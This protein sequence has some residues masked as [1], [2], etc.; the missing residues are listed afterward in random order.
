LIVLATCAACAACS[1]GSSR[2]PDGGPGD[3]GPGD[4]S[5]GDGGTL[6]CAM[7]VAAYC[8][9]AGCKTALADARQDRA[10]CPASITPCGEFDVIVKSQIDTSTSYFYFRGQL[11]AVDHTLLPGR[12]SCIAG[13][14]T[15]TPPTCT[16]PSQTLPA[17]Q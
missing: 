4:G 6:T 15:F 13:P 2:S 9:V 17:C 5:P 16:Q 7:T 1:S 3:G 11:L 10:L 14:S 8:N 12:A